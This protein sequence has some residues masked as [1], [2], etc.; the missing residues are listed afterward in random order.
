MSTYQGGGEGGGGALLV[1][2]TDRSNSAYGGETQHS[3]HQ[4]LK[5]YKP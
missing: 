2:C 5:P 1:G 3:Q 4:V